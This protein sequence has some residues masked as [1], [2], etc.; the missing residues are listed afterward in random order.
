[1]VKSVAAYP[2][3]PPLGS[4]GGR[5]QGW[6]LDK[7]ARS[8]SVTASDERGVYLPGSKRSSSRAVKK[9]LGVIRL[10]CVRLPMSNRT[11]FLDVVAAG[12]E[13]IA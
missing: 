5:R 13:H 10:N 8:R 11:I 3:R 7:K 4:S 2:I 1:M 6:H 12:P 9:S